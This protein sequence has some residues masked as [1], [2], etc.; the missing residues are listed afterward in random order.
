MSPFYHWLHFTEANTAELST[1]GLLVT[2]DRLYIIIQ[3]DM[4]DWNELI[5]A[6]SI[7]QK[8][9]ERIETQWVEREGIVET[10]KW[11]EIGKTIDK[12]ARAVIKERERERMNT[13]DP[14]LFAYPYNSLT[15]LPFTQSLIPCYFNRNDLLFEQVTKSYSLL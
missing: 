3:V 13:D 14:S 4:S 6:M 15:Q 7:M 9:M 8:G 11:K 10:H 2:W 1:I 5:Y 12:S